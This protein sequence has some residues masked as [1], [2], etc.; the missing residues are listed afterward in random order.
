MLIA[1]KLYE[2]ML[3]AAVPG[4]KRL[5]RRSS[6]QMTTT[7]VLFDDDLASGCSILALI[8][9]FGLI[10]WSQPTQAQTANVNNGQPD[11][12][13]ITGESY[14]KRQLD[15]FSW[16]YLL[17]VSHRPDHDAYDIQFNNSFTSRFYLL[18]DEVQSIQDAN[19]ARLNAR[20]MLSR[21]SAYGLALEASSLRVSNTNLQQDYAMAGPLIRHQKYV[22][23][24]FSLLGGYL[25]EERSQNRDSGLMV[26]IRGEAPV[27]EIGELMLN[28]ELYINYADIDPRELHT[29]RFKTNSRM[30][31]DDFRM[32]AD[33][34]LARN[35]RESYQSDSFFNRGNSDFIESIQTDTTAVSGTAWF[36]LSPAVNARLDIGG[37]RYL[38][39]TINRSL[40]DENEREEALVDTRVMRQELDLRLEAGYEM[41][42]MELNGGLEYSLGT[43]TGQLQNPSELSSEQVLQQNEQL[44]N[45]NFEQQHFGMFSESQL[46]LHPDNTT[47]INGRISIFN[48]DTPEINRD[49]RDELNVALSL[50]NRHRF[51]EAFRT[52]MLVSA[53]GRH[54][55][56][57]FSER[58]IQNNWRRSLR[59]APGIDWQILPWLQSYH[60]FLV[61]ANY[62]VYDFQSESAPNNDQVSRE[63]KAGSRFEVDLAPDW[64]LDMALSRSELRIGRLLW[65]EFREIPTDT[66]VT[67]DSRVS[68][69][70]EKAGLLS[71]IGLR[72]FLKLEYLPAATISAENPD[73]PGETVSRTGPGRQQSLQWGPTV[74]L[75]LPLYARN[76]LYISGWYQIQRVKRRLYTEY[77]EELRDAFRAAEDKAQISIFP[78]IEIRA[79]F[80]F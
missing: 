63:F 34:K 4:I 59:L 68:I 66:L 28:S 22:P 76:E 47:R 58:S 9:F 12:T 44:I 77:P 35:I 1:F 38:R 29:Y 43:R 79:R 78:N 23:V 6:R 14:F 17:D 30:S 27:Y 72:Y 18:N 61:R 32:D 80:R 57:L 70:L 20:I 75:R 37:L 41:D 36:P 31:G 26:G 8:I 55:V 3:V 50:S 49:D 51:Q 73:Q 52:R 71:S 54:T 16:R 56:Y 40:R 2:K 7:C 25:Q 62:T 24:Q 53:E 10:L 39:R 13:A 64:Q 67:Y 65:D 46:Q 60:D 74:D 15:Q 5:C 11:N 42:I 69:S 21:K 48:Y 19:T 45:S 33:L